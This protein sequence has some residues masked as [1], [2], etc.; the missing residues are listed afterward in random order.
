MIIQ[1]H[2]PL[3]Q[4][5]ASLD[6]P[7]DVVEQVVA[8]YRR[9]CIWLGE[10]DSPLHDYDPELYPQGSFRLGT[11]VHP[12]S[13]L[14]G[15]DIDLVCRLDIAKQ[16]VTQKQLKQMV[17]DRLKLDPLTGSVVRESR[18]CWTI[19]YPGPFHMDV[20]PALEDN[21]TGG[22]A[23]ILTDRELRLWQYSNP[24]GYADWFFNQM[25]VR[26]EEAKVRI[27]KGRGVSITDVQAWEARTPLQRAV[28][29]LK[30]HRDTRFP[31]EGPPSIIL[32]TLAAHAYG[33]EESIEV[34]LLRILQ[35]FEVG[36]VKKGDNWWVEN[37][38]HPLENFADKWNETPAK[39]DLFYRWLDQARIDA[40]AI[41]NANS[42]TDARVLIEKAIGRRQQAALVKQG[43]ATGLLLESAA[44]AQAP[45]WP[46]QTTGFVC[47][48]QAGVHR[49]QKEGKQLW[50]LDGRPIHKKA[51]LRFEAVT[52]VPPP[53]EVKWRVTNT[54][55]DARRAGHL[56]GGFEDGEGSGGSVRWERTAYRGVH[57][58]E[59][60]VIK[61]GWVVAKSESVRVPIT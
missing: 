15:F 23:I 51:G 44:H 33:N 18:R 24:I 42:D 17:G 13:H 45:R 30:R 60:F 57:L 16:S 49:R 14:G 1:P 21:D 22:T 39:R 31:L 27:A 3:D 2:E 6:I 61:D 52:D 7:P 40:A 11:P 46:V 19:D 8:E 47:H 35:N 43:P 25:R 5:L 12:V 29:F 53:Y 37:P 50:R 20:L 4:A 54:G 59:A 38:A 41:A 10:P 28:Q 9:V 26:L 32:T 48:V 55:P 58:V 34:A 56:R 36:I